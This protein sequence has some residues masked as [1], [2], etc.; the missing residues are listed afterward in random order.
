MT[1]MSF[2]NAERRASFPARTVADSGR[3]YR[4]ALRHSRFV[5]FLR[6]GLIVVIAVVL[7]GVVVDNYLPPIG[8][9]RLPGEVGKLV[10]KGT[11]ITMQEP[12]L[13]GFTSDSRAYEFSANTAAQDITK[14]DLVELE[15]IRAKIEMAD[16]SIVRL[17]SDNGVYNMKSDMLDLNSNIHVVSSTGYE[18]RLSQATVDVNKGDVVSDTPVWVKLLDGDLNAKHLEIVE[19]GDVVRFTDVTMVLQP[20]NKDAKAGEQ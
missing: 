9:L 19:K 6:V 5:R 13:T 15:K 3:T 18:A 10:I 14:P 7:V 1:T 16:K 2:A 11:T 4:R 17:W 8:G 20:N 12:R